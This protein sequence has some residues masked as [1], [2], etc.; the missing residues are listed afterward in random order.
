MRFLR[1]AALGVVIIGLASATT[2]SAQ[3]T[4]AP[5]PPPVLNDHDLLRKYVLSTLG[6]PGALGATLASG[7]DQ[8]RGA[9]DGWET[10]GA[11]YAKR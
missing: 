6:P 10:D 3:E 11:G 7:L 4:P 2:S 8:W 9:P 5:V 1:F